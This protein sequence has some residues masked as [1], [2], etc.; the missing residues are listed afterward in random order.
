MPID[1]GLLAIGATKTLSLASANSFAGGVSDL[2]PGM[3]GAGGQV[4]ISAANILILASDQTAPAADAG[5][6]ILD[7]D[8]IS[9]LGAASVLIG[10][11][12]APNATGAGSAAS[13][14]TG[15]I[16]TPTAIN[17]EVATDAAHSLTGPELILVTTTSPTPKLD[18]DGNQV[19]DANGNPVYV[20]AGNGLTIDSGSVIRAVGT[21]PAGT[22]QN[23]TSAA[24][25]PAPAATARY[26]GSPTGRR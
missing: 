12:S 10:G 6:L 5:Y 14:A 19:T 21:V 2:A 11:T 4:D 22:D 1:G 20:N 15:N 9:N 24:L 7:A 16:I 13:S 25:T 8:Q 18:A 3:T 17:L 23:I 26:C